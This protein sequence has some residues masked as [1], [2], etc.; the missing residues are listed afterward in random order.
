VG[1][2][3]FDTFSAPI[4]IF[5]YF[6]GTFSTPIFLSLFVLFLFLEIPY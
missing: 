1:T 5:L 6:F 2:Y 4:F 3:F